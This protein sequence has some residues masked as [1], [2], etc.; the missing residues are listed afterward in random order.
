V[1]VIVLVAA[2]GYAQL[3]S[4]TALPSD[5]RA[6]FFLGNATTCAQVGF[7]DSVH[8]GSDDNTGASDA[9]VAGTVVSQAEGSA[10]NVAITPAGTAAGVVVDA[11]VVKGSDGYNLYHAA[12]VLPPALAPPQL[13]LPPRTPSGHIADISHWFV[14]YH[15]PAL[16]VGSLM[17]DKDVIPPPG[18]PAQPL[19]TTFSVLV[20]CDNP[21]FVPVT[22][23]FGNGG[24]AASAAAQAVIEGLP[25][26]TFCTV[27]EQ[28][29]G[30]FPAGTVVTYT[31]PEA[32]VPPGVEIGPNG[33]VTVTVTNDF[34]GVAVQT[35]TVRV[36]KRVAGLAGTA[37]PASFRAEVG[38]DDGTR[39]TLTLPGTG[40]PAN[41]PVTV[42][43]GSVCAVAEVAS[44]VPAGWTVTY[45]VDG[46]TA[47][48][49]PPLFTVDAGHTVTVTV[50]NTAPGLAATG[51]PAGLLAALAGVLILAGAG[52]LLL[53]RRRGAARRAR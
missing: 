11:V 18:P 28:N 43:A 8:L 9:F 51:T 26:G 53:T 31:P 25:V 19:P 27:V 36:V 38:C 24:G 5:P 1:L 48:T 3:P 20:T 4:L 34:S 7:P 6:D 32:A 35:G 16:P 39:R 50:T 44:S 41:E 12:Q 17:V 30:S 49:R 21:G 40:G 29:T 46:G 23:V 22:I 14:C 52:T 45:S 10:L 47:T 13:Y 2:P 37:A 33:G 15:L 42:T